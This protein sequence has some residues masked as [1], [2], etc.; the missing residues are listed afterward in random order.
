MQFALSRSLLICAFCASLSLTGAKQVQQQQQQATKLKRDAA[1]SFGSGLYHGPSH[2]YL[3]PSAVTSGYESTYASLHGNGLASSSGFDF[4]SLDTDN[5]H[6]HYNQHHY[7]AQHGHGLGH[8][9]GLGHGYGLGHAQGHGHGHGRPVYISSAGAAGY[10]HHHHQQQ[11]PHSHRPKVETYIVQTSNPHHQSHGNG[12]AG[13]L[14]LGL[15][16]GLGG[17]YK[18]AGS[19]GG[20]LNLLSGAHKQ[21]GGNTY[22][23]ATPTY[24]TNH[25]GAGHGLGGHEDHSTAGYSYEAPSV[26]FKQPLSSYGV[27]ILPNYE[28]EEQEQEQEQEQQS[29]HQA[30]HT[31]HNHNHGDQ[32][33]PA[34]ALGHKGLG[35]FSYTSSKPHALNTDIHQHQQEAPFKPSA[36]LGAKHEPSPGFDFATPTSSSSS[37][38]QFLQPPTAAGY[39]YAHPAPPPSVLY[40]APAQS[41]DS[42]APIFEPEST[43]LPPV[44]SYGAPAT[45]THSYH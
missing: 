29:E 39:D 18:Y 10:Q 34:Y 11:Q 35:H 23:L 28:H 1:L 15:A 41:G 31:P 5:S 43:Y 2:K 45:P 9:Y 21:H 4:A 16:G 25:A 33:P 17:G 32:Q 30:E 24:S 13:G 44:S 40:G 7:S 27:P 38:H 8:I 12:L 42:A 37:S 36:F 26:H 14:G 19:S 6:H 3:P 20:F 22:L